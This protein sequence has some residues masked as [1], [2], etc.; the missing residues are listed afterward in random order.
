MQFDIYIKYTHTHTNIRRTSSQTL[1][2]SLSFPFLSF[3][4]VSS[5]RHNQKKGT[6][7]RAEKGKGRDR[8]YDCDSLCACLCV[9]V[10]VHDWVV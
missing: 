8:Q 1:T 9:G 10:S 4:L 7:E 5:S 6:E 2:E 3:P